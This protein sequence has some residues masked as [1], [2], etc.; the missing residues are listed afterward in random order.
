MIRPAFLPLALAGVLAAAGCGATRAER[1][2]LPGASKSLARHCAAGARHAVGSPRSAYA[3]V[4]RRPLNAFRAPGKGVLRHFGVLNVNGV[5][6]VLGVVGV[7]VD[8]GC[9]ASWYRV[10]L[11][12]RPNGATGWVRASDVELEVVDT[13]IVVDLSARRVTFFRSGRPVLI[14]RAA[15]GASGTPTPTGRYYVNQRL[16]PADKNGPFGPGA[17]GIS[18]YSRVLTHWAQGGPIAIHGT[19][20][21]WSIGHAVSNGCIRVPNDVLRRLFDATPSGTPVLIRG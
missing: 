14:T 1:A 15:V 6:T 21:P 9:G 5:P 19:N 3:A 17:I 20:Q 11:P 18:A 2:G 4:V 12:I 16:I 13:R 8:S 10:Q 7:A